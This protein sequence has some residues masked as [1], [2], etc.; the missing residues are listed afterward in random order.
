MKH[1]L[2]VTTEERNIWNSTVLAKSKLWS[3][4]PLRNQV[5]EKL[6]SRSS[7][8]EYSPGERMTD[9]WGAV[10]TR[11]ISLISVSDIPTPE[12]NSLPSGLTFKAMFLF[13][14]GPVWHWKH[15]LLQIWFDWTE[16][17]R[18]F[19]TNSFY[20]LLSLPWAILTFAIF[21]SLSTILLATVS[22]ILV[23][24]IPNHSHTEFLQ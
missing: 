6:R 14:L 15:I 12:F 7:N 4:V 24:F 21:Q 19:S 23:A 13:C 16:L 2:L 5:L 3:E 10:A 8:K 22:E 9:G 18:S 1:A 20:H 17:A 11:R